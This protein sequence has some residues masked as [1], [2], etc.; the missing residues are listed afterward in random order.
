MASKE[1]DI[2]RTAM[3]YTDRY[4]PLCCAV[5]GQRCKICT[6]NGGNG[7]KRRLCAMGINSCS[8]IEVLKSEGHGPVILG[9]NDTRLALGR[10][11]A[12]KIVV[13]TL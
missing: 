3:Q 6:I 2:H 4:V 11:M 13:E 10:G 7:L 5:E 1:K 8:E 9:I 12:S